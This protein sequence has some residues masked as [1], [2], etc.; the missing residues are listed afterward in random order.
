MMK[1]SKIA[2]AFFILSSLTL[3]QPLLSIKPDTLKFGY[4]STGGSYERQ[5]TLYNVGDQRLTIESCDHL[6]AFNIDHIEGLQIEPGDSAI[7]SAIFTPEAEGLYNSSFEFTYNNITEPRYRMIVVARGVPS[8]E[9]G[10]IIWSYQHIDDVV[11]VSAADDDNGDGFPEVVAEGYDNGANGNPLVCLSGSGAGNPQTI[12]STRPPGGPSNSGGNGD[13]CLKFVSDLNGDGHGDIIR[14]TSWNGRTISAIDGVTGDTIWIYDTNSHPPTGWVYSV[15]EMEDITDDGVPEILAG[16]GSDANRAY[17]LNGATGEFI[18]RFFLEDGAAAVA[19]IPDVNDDGFADAIIAPLDNGVY[20]YCVSGHSEGN[21]S[22][23][24]RAYVGQNSFDITIMNDINSDGHEDV[25]IGT[26][27]RGLVAL[28]GQAD[29]TGHFLWNYNNGT[30]TMRVVTCPDLN[31]DG[32][33]DILVG[34]WGSYAEAVSGRDGSSIWR[35]P[36]GSNV[37]AIDYVADINGDGIIEVVAGSFNHNVYLLDGQTGDIMWQKDVGA[38][39]L[40]LRGTEDINGDGY[41]DVIAGT[42]MDNGVGGEVFMLSGW[43][44]EQTY[45]SE[46]DTNLPQTIGLAYNYPNPFN[47]TTKIRFSLSA[48]ADYTISIYDISGRLVDTIKDS[49]LAGTNSI[50]WSLSGKDA[51]ASG[52]YFYKITAG[53]VA[54]AGKMTYLK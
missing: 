6:E 37:W 18:W 9:R 21:A 39:V 15:D 42:Q 51:V 1:Y 27:G 45:I 43:G 41:A 46:K 2:I 36:C 47:S 35:T 20:A 3:A 48:A 53:D 30:Y 13:Q 34:S 5:M 50:T 26:W 23:I 31:G 40:T 28:S 19:A 22:R 10:D 52:V 12:W 8:F 29:S 17:C 25:V 7:V 38:R 49:G 44:A 54:V 4:I 33:E 32:Y 11:C 16:I 24:W 14:G